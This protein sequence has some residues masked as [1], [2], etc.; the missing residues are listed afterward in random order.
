MSSQTVILSEGS[1]TVC[2]ANA[3]EGSGSC[4]TERLRLGRSVASWFA[5]LCG[6]A[7][8]SLATTTTAS[9]DDSTY[10][11]QAQAINGEFLR[12]L[13]AP[14]SGAAAICIVD[15]GVNIT[16]DLED[17]VIA[18]YALDGGSVDDLSSLQYGTIVAQYTAGA[19]NG[20]GSVGIWPAAQVISVRATSSSDYDSFGWAGYVNGLLRCTDSAADLGVTLATVNF[21]L[22]DLDASDTNNDALDEY[23]TYTRT[24]VGSSTVASAG[25]DSDTEA[26]DY[27]A[28]F[29]DAIAVGASDTADGSF[30]EFSNRGEGLD[31]SAPGCGLDSADSS[32]NSVDQQGTSLA[33]PTVSAVLAALRSYAPE[34]SVDEAETLLLDSAQT[35]SAGKV[36]DAEATFRAAGLGYLVDTYA[37]VDDTVDSSTNGNSTQESQS[38]TAVASPGSATTAASSTTVAATVTANGTNTA[39][40]NVRKRLKRPRVLSTYRTKRRLYLWLSR[41]PKGATVVVK[42]GSRTLRFRRSQLKDDRIA[43]TMH[44]WRK[45]KVRFSDPSGTKSASRWLKVGPVGITRGL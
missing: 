34:L 29:E 17:A 21:S 14:S 12:D 32:G 28:R 37:P 41:V 6:V 13:P 31:L 24:A 35:T 15:T 27:P 39:T 43:L 3:V 1:E 10:T 22:G 18:R 11:R 2:L 26:V 23:I 20:W 16:P 44:R 9:A 33:A 45:V 30:C 40:P 42:L 25:N 5:A 19:K 36:L 7:A 8:I 38:G 4:A